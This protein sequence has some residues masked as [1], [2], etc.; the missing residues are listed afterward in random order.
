MKEGTQEK[1]TNPRHIER[2]QLYPYHPEMR[3][4]HLA[5]LVGY[6]R[7]CP[8]TNVENDRFWSTPDQKPTDRKCPGRS[9]ILA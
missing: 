9:M 6:R 5:P 7:G 1:W 4:T 2:L 8:Q 3:V